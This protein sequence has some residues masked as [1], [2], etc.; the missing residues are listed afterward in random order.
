VVSSCLLAIL[1]LA[2]GLRVW[3]I[4]FGLPYEFT[5]DE[6]HEIVRAFKLGAG[7]FDWDGFF[8]GGLYYFL[9][10]EY[11][12]I[13]VVWKLTGSVANAQEF[14]MQYFQDPTPFYLA[15]R[16]TVAVMGTLTCWVVF[17]I[18]RRLYNV[19]VG[20]GAALI[21]AT[22]HYHALW[23]HYINVDIGQ[24][25][26]MWT[27]ILAYLKYEASGKRRWLL[28]AGALGG[29]GI[30]FKVTGAIVLPVLL[31]AIATPL[32]RW[33]EPL[34]MIKESFLVVLSLM[35]ALTVVA[36][37]W[38]FYS[39]NFDRIFN[40]TSA[41]PEVL[42]ENLVQSIDMVTIYRSKSYW[43]YLELLARPYNIA[44]AVCALYAI[45]LAL[46]RRHRWD[47]IWASLIIVFL[48]IMSLA[49]RNSPERYLLP[50]MPAFWLLSM[51]AIAA[52]TNQRPWA[53]A[54][55]LAC[56]IALPL[57]T[58]MYHNYMWTK[59]DTRA[60]AKQWIESHIPSGAKILM[61]GQRYRFV[62]SPPLRP[63]ATAVA[64]RLE[65][66]KGA[67]RVSRGASSSA[68]GIYDEAM[69]HIEGPRYDLHSTVWG[70][71]VEPL[72]YYVNHCFDYVITSS[73]NTMRYQDA[74]AQQL[75]PKSY[76]FYT[77]L[78]QDPRFKAVYRIEPKAWQRTGP[79]I[80]VYR[81]QHSCS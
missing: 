80:A 24:T 25:L 20:L 57:A 43:G 34:N 50:L 1:V 5:Y 9:F 75:F 14:A 76:Q 3:G 52:F 15:G 81:V 19:W 56:V 21:G 12:V 67:E 51:R 38:I 79:E 35:I 63:D 61:D 60:V 11:G 39:I 36:P 62:M 68:F 49:S 64:R 6:V 23:S 8:K 26:A 4:D 59:P 70:Q 53:T 54:L 16:L 48:V 77:Q 46:W 10:V 42:S 18:G 37:E 2:L 44:V 65:K 41:P 29:V 27:S 78:P 73:F 30:A 40:A 69:G 55:A 58:L 74:Q 45:G 33:R 72:S 47:L 28:A 31:L 71:A 13:Y 17:C 66:V 7:E 32:R 22:A